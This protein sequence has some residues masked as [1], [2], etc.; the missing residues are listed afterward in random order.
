MNDTNAYLAAIIKSNVYLDNPTSMTYGVFDEG[1]K[2]PLDCSICI[3]SDTDYKFRVKDPED[4][5]CFNPHQLNQYLEQRNISFE[6]EMV[7]NVYNVMC[8]LRLMR[9]TPDKDILEHLNNSHDDNVPLDITELWLRPVIGEIRSDIRTIKERR[10]FWEQHLYVVGGSGESNYLDQLQQ[11][12]NYPVC[13][14]LIER[15]FVE[16]HWND[17][18]KEQ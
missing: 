12:L 5:K 8:V 18:I 1:G 16:G 13:E 7:L 11:D 4:T 6:P 2:G 9:D 10:E 14:N 3:G 17:G 15:L